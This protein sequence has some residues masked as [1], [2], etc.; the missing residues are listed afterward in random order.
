MGH[1]YP[2]RNVQVS[3]EFDETMSQWY[4]MPAVRLQVDNGSKDVFDH[5][6]VVSDCVAIAETR[7]WFDEVPPRASPASQLSANQVIDL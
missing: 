4:G 2:Y 6:P 3:N 7:K 1:P 5:V